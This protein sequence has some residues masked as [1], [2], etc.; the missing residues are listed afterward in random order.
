M[1][2]SIVEHAVNILKLRADASEA[3]ANTQAAVRQMAQNHEEHKKAIELLGRAA[4][5]YQA[6]LDTTLRGHVVDEVTRL[7]QRI[8]EVAAGGGSSTATRPF[9]RADRYSR[10]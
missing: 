9:A 4:E 3:V 7:R 1:G 5:Q 10:W 6:N 2:V 8:E